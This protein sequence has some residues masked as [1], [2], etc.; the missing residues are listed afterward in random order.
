MPPRL[1]PDHAR[2]ELSPL[3]TAGKGAG[4][5]LPQKPLPRLPACQYH[6][7]EAWGPKGEQGLACSLLF[8]FRHPG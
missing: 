5:E 2:E 7:R 6:W 4:V 8:T 1:Q 3:V